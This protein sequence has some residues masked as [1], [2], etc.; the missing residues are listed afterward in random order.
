[1]EFPVGYHR[2]AGNLAHGS[3]VNQHLTAGP[4]Y[5]IA[6]QRYR[7]DTSGNEQLLSG[8]IQSAF[9]PA[10][11][12]LKLPAQYLAPDEFSFDRAETDGKA[13]GGQGE[14]GYLFSVGIG[15]EFMTVERETGFQSQCIPGT[16]SHRSNAEFI[17]EFQ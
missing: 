13:G 6:Q 5:A 11:D 17:T 2:T 3:A 7:V 1:M 10:L 9:E 4:G 15:A 14:Y 8:H 12:F 16:K